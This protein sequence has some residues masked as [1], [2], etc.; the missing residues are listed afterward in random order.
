VIAVS[1]QHFG[2]VKKCVSAWSV[3]RLLEYPGLVE[4]G[5]WTRDRYAFS[6]RKGSL[7]II[8]SVSVSERGNFDCA[9][10]SEQK[11]VFLRFFF[12]FCLLTAEL[13]RIIILLRFLSFFYSFCVM[14]DLIFN[15]HVHMHGAIVFLSSNC[16]SRCTCS[17]HHLSS[18]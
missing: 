10:P 9:R 15:V 13:C 3:I 11:P 4:A 2:F 1:S 8:V 18:P 12:L 5:P 14:F 6:G 7:A 17:H 16:R